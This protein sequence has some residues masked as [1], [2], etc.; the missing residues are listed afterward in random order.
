M[1]AA[2]APV[3]DLVG[4]DPN[5]PR[6]IVFQL[7]R[8]EAHL[9]ALPGR[10]DEGRLSPSEQVATALTARLRTADAGSIDEN[11]LLDVE[12]SL[13]KLSDVVASSYF[14]TH[15]RSDVPWDSL[16]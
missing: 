13:M 12:A 1:V 15:M 7:A 10:G 14:T 9:A 4:L 3:I 11:V 5:N 6:S 16:G 8:I 2:R